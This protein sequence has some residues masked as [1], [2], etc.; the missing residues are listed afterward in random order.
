MEMKETKGLLMVHTGNGKGKTTAAIGLAVRAWGQGLQILI[1]QFIK[2]KWK[3]GELKALEK[4][5]PQLEIRQMGQGF[6]QKTA[7]AAA[8][9]LHQAAAREALQQAK[10]E[11]QSGLWDLVILDEINYA[12]KFGLLHL[13]DVMEIIEAKPAH[14]HLLLTGRDAP[15]EIIARADLVTEMRAVKHPYEQGIKA[16]QGIEF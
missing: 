7:D 3:Y 4:F 8:F 10:A 6:T 2:G 5:S 16:Q 11:L 13:A 12:V 14:M 9:S 1:L 15:P